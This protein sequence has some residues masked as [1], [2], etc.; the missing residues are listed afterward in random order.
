MLRGPLLWNLDLGISTAANNDDCDNGQKSVMM[1]MMMMIRK[2]LKEERTGFH[3]N[4]SP[5]GWGWG[6]F[7]F[8]NPY[9]Y[10]AQLRRPKKITIN[11]GQ[12]FHVI[13]SLVR[14]R[15]KM[16]MMMTAKT[17]TKMEMMMTM[18]TSTSLVSASKMQLVLRRTIRGSTALS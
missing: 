5:A 17:M 3:S 8:P 6:G 12:N 9:F 16:V 18:M 1:L 13:F 10:P 15:R 2:T 11:S 7:L 4:S 14:R